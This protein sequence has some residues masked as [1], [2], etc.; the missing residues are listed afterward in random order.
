MSFRW[1]WQIRKLKGHSFISKCHRFNSFPS[2]VAPKSLHLADLLLPPVIQ[3]SVLDRVQQ[4]VHI[5][6]QH[7]P[8]TRASTAR[9]LLPWGQQSNRGTERQQRASSGG[10]TFYD[11]R[12]RLSCDDMSVCF[13]HFA[14]FIWMYFWGGPHRPKD[15]L[16]ILFAWFNN[17]SRD[18]LKKQ[19]TNKKNPFAN[20]LS[21]FFL[22]QNC[23]NGA[24]TMTSPPHWG[25]GE[26]Q[27]LTF[28][29]SSHK[30]A[31]FLGLW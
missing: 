18:H 6:P 21:C 20:A 28:F 13:S 2:G 22:L 27:Y 3:C 16:W 14:G 4:L 23:E 1:L 30:I 29:F 7:A 25:D 19:K 15:S 8:S 11:E 31:R 10:W 12:M 24:I 26:L 9:L 17:L 5:I